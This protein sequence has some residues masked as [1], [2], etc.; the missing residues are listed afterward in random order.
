M[1]TEE[2]KEYI[3]ANITTNG[4]GEISGE[5]LNEILNG[6]VDAI[7]GSTL[8]VTKIDN[9]EGVLTKEE[10]A[11]NLGITETEVD[12]LFK[13]D[14]HNVRYEEREDDILFV[15]NMPL[16]YYDF[17]LSVGGV[18]PYGSLIFGTTNG[19]GGRQLSVFSSDD[20]YVISYYEI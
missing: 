7:E 16:V 14:Y 15:V 4:K 17:E 6:I 11:A 10:F 18:I 12:N 13:G 9:G 19:D 20:G 2:L 1:N 8:T 3:D 5:K